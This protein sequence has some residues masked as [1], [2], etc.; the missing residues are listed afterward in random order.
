MIAEKWH[1]RGLAL[2]AGFVG[3]F[4]F[5]PALLS[6]KSDLIPQ[7]ASVSSITSVYV[8]LVG[9]V[10]SILFLLSYDW[11]SKRTAGLSKKRIAVVFASAFLL[12]I[13][14][15][16]LADIVDSTNSS[17]W[18][19]SR[20]L[21]PADDVI[22]ETNTEEGIHYSRLVADT[23]TLGDDALAELAPGGWPLWMSGGRVEVLLRAWHPDERA[24]E[25]PCRDWGDAIIVTGT[26]EISAVV[27]SA[28]ASELCNTWRRFDIALPPRTRQIGYIVSAD[29]KGGRDSRSLD[30]AIL[31]ASPD[32]RIFWEGIRVIAFSLLLGFA[33]LLMS[34]NGRAKSAFD[35]PGVVTRAT[36]SSRGILFAVAILLFLSVSNI[37]VYWFVSQERTIYTWDF[38]GYWTSSRHVSDV[39][40]GRASP[41][42]ASEFES[43]TAVDTSTERITG[44]Q[45]DLPK[46]SRDPLTSLVRN[47]RYSE[48]NI[49]N[50]MPVAVAMVLFG[51]SRM[52]YELSLT[53]EY[54]L[55][56]MIALL[57]ALTV[58]ARE[59]CRTWKS[60]WP[61]CPAL[62][63]IAFVPFWVPIV[64]GYIGVC[65]VAVNLLAIW[66]YFRP[67]QNAGELVSP[68]IIGL[69]FVVGLLLQ[70][71]NA[72]W[73]VA[74]LL[75]ALLDSTWR[76][77]SAP[78]FEFDYIV[79]CFRVPLIAGS[80]AFLTL[81]VIAWP[82]V[83]T[84][85]TT[86]YSDIYS[87]FSEH[88]TMFAE[89]EQLV[90]SFGILYLLLFAAAVAYLVAKR[91]TRRFAILL[92]VQ[93][94][95]MFV[96]FSNT[97]TMGQHHLYI[98]MPGMFLILSV[99]VI[100]AISNQSIRV[101]GAGIALLCLYLVNGIVSGI[102]VFSPGGD[103]VR[104][105]LIPLVPDNRRIPLVRYDIDE[106]G[107]LVA[108]LDEIVDEDTS[109][110][111]IYVLSSSQTLNTVHL[112]NLEASTGFRFRAAEKMLRPSEVDKRDGFPRQLMHA[113][114]VVVGDPIQYNRR[115][116][117]QFVVGIP[118]QRIIDG[119][120]IGAA[121]ELMPRSFELEGGVKA[122]IFKKKREM[123]ASELADFS[124]R[125]QA[126]YPDRP[127]VYR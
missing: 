110:Q 49:T 41:S 10:T 43:M 54:A 58:F 103:P 107:R 80:A 111:G 117:D 85:A 6:A 50:N 60:W 34:G 53:N 38:A 5:G 27:V 23:V 28:S 127:Y 68:I 82:L 122:R 108:Y 90:Q 97:Q 102:A 105:A 92:S 52:V 95:V 100:E 56:A 67:R 91:T 69:L 44:Q 26:R 37:F 76:F 124:S 79:E 106:F 32:F 45:S 86:D 19:Y 59:P 65:V 18:R 30:I 2:I 116:T 39:L 63:V 13:A 81:S 125:L 46:R 93:L 15:W 99:A 20:I 72:Y 14:G 35:E 71:W 57:I 9:I 25:A 109:V 89:I 123:S 8:V 42:S 121:F 21:V 1:R 118:A 120:G 78:R 48:Y 126:V 87:A 29:N 75:V 36:R 51:G 114:I 70:R 98:L 31:R 74:F 62:V 16:L 104:A 119:T 7:S 61:L 77:L 47:V 73:I 66:L 11:L 96:H 22:A 88:T 12:S 55:A 84:M 17:T 33:W 113:D 40:Q 64:R 24:A 112:R 94:V 3:A 101:R 4:G 115:P 83:V